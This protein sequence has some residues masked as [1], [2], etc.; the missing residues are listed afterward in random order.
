MKKR[1]LFAGILAC[2]LTLTLA[3][4]GLSGADVTTLSLIHI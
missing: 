3:A 1:H 2:A 4:C